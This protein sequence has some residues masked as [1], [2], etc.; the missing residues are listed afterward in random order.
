VPGSRPQ[1]VLSELARSRWLLVAFVL[2]S[3]LPLVYPSLYWLTIMCYLFTAG[4]FALSYDLVLGRT[5]VLSFGHAA[6][7]GLGAY[8]VYWVYSAGYPFMLA[9]VAA[10]LL[11]AAV[12]AAMG[13]ALRRVKGVYF[14]MFTLAFAEI[15][16]L[17]LEK[18]T[19]ITGGSSGVFSPRPDFLQDPN[20]VYVF[21][22]IL[23]AAAAG[24]LC[25]LAF[26]YVRKGKLAKGLVGIVVLVLL[27][28][29]AVY[30]LGASVISQLQTPIAAFTVNAYFLSALLMF[31][32]YYLV[33]R[34][35]RSPLG[36]IMTAIRENDERTDMIGYD[37]FRYRLVIMA[38]SGLFA[39]L[40]GAML[41]SLATFIVTPDVMS[42]TYTLNVLLYSILGGI[43][44]LVGP[45]IGAFVV[46][47]LHFNIGNIASF[48]GFPSI[49]NW[50]MLIIGVFYI[51]VVLFLPYGIVGTA[52]VK[53]R[54]TLDVLRKALGM[55]GGDGSHG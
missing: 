14:A 37:T 51:A 33:S 40:S 50:W 44:T 16:Y 52:M 38:I 32:S 39:G 24:I 18:Q 36:A 19:S 21:T 31:V 28:A 12:N 27:V 30:N 8:A 45:I 17:Y 5:G 42:A 43:G 53:G 23:A 29:Y 7:F 46:E 22:A 13:T 6:C 54:R 25:F 35:A 3:L 2:A 20:L 55:K 10:M 48:V 4:L 9:V 1:A 47:F 49:A 15:I 26:S 11:G 41:A 34:L